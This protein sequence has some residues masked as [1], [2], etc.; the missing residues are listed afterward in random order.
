MSAAHA[1]A[2][3]GGLTPVGASA[4]RRVADD[5][6]AM[7]PPPSW[8]PVTLR[9]AV[10]GDMW[11]TD[12]DPLEDYVLQQDPRAK[13]AWAIISSLPWLLN[14]SAWFRAGLSKEQFAT[15]LRRNAYKRHSSPRLL[16]G[17]FEVMIP[18]YTPKRRGGLTPQ[19]EMTAEDRKERLMRR[20]ARFEYRSRV[21]A[22][23]YWEAL[24]LTGLPRLILIKILRFLELR[25]DEMTGPLMYCMRCK[26][27]MNLAALFSHVSVS[28]VHINAAVA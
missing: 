5:A 24:L 27:H 1:N 6:M 3:A 8:A 4:P 15:E 20:V 22:N 21:A 7:P 23:E 14:G 17:V 2:D 10:W 16:D 28:R 9:T 18:G 11:Q 13:D 12:P 19:V 25:I 26:E